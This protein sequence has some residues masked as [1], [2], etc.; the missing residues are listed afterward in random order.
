MPIADALL[1]FYP[2]SESASENGPVVNGLLVAAVKEVLALTRGEDGWRRLVPPLAPLVQE[3]RDALRTAL[4][5]TAL[6][7]ALA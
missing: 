7:P 5:A 4:G 6:G 1:D 3:Q 2:T